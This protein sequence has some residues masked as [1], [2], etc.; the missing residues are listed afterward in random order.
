MVMS[1]QRSHRQLQAT[2]KG[3]IFIGSLS[4]LFCVLTVQAHADDWTAIT[5]EK[6]YHLSS[7]I[8]YF[9]DSV[10]PV[11]NNPFFSQEM[12][13]RA[14]KPYWVAASYALIPGFFIPSAFGHAI[15]GDNTEA[16]II[17]T[18]RLSGRMMWMYAFF[19]NIWKRDADG[20]FSKGDNLLFSLG[21]LLDIGGYLFDMTN[22]PQELAARHKANSRK[23]VSNDI[24][25]R[26]FIDMVDSG[27]SCGLEAKF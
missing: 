24:V 15:A 22:G 4:L 23:V 1:G 3:L 16:S 13:P 2:T 11:A 14:S 8:V 7:E 20:H 12:K 10:D 18:A 9:G 25:I 17:S 21:L 6:K 27:P 19:E 5:I 26:P